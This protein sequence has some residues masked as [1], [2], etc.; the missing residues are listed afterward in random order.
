MI[1]IEYELEKLT[2]TC[3]EM[4]DMVSIQLQKCRKVMLDRNLELADDIVRKEIRVNA[5]EL[6]IERECENILAL[7]TPAAADFRFVIAILKTS[8][9][10]ERIGDHAFHMAEYVLNEEINLTKEQIIELKIDVMF[11]T[12]VEMLSSAITALENKD[13]EIAKALFKMDKTLDKITD[14]APDIIEKKIMEDKKII[15]PFLYAY[16]I[17]GKLERIGDLIKNIGEE[18]I[19]YVES[20]IIRH[21][22]RNKKIFRTYIKEQE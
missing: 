9:N 8:S 19:Y 3:Y 14:N 16:R 22:K 7:K 11:K 2:K 18:I 12:A 6:N 10:L 4:F 13:T 17:V 21:K 5:L 15:Q 20:D 1:P